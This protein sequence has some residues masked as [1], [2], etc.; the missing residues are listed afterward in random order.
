MSDAVTDPDLLEPNRRRFDGVAPRYDLL[1]RLL[2]A[3]RDVAWRRRAVR[4]LALSGGARV[5]DLATGT[6]DVAMEVCRQHAE[7]TVLGLDVSGEMLALGRRKV[8]RAHLADRIELRTGNAA[9]LPLPEASFDAVTCA[10]GIR[11]MPRRRQ[12]FREARRVLRGGGR[13]VVLE[14]TRPGRGVF[15]RAFA[16]YLTRLVPAIGAMLS[17]RGAYRYLADSIVGFPE[18]EVICSE[19]RRA[20]FGRAQAHRLTLG[21][22][23]LFVGTVEEQP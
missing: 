14:L 5:L 7:A 17:R 11:N 12:V 8:A 13:M 23:T 18:P 3:G 4:D 1:N 16:W 6:A 2:S 20:G 9:E 15:L 21:I 19:M 22:A 10:F